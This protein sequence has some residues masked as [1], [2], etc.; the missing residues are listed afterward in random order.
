MKEVKPDSTAIE[1]SRAC[2]AFPV[3]GWGQC[4]DDIAVDDGLSWVLLFF[5]EALLTS[6]GQIV[7]T[8]R[9]DISA[10]PLAGNTLGVGVLT[11]RFFL[12][13]LLALLFAIC[14]VSGRKV[15]TSL[16]SCDTE[17]RNH[18]APKLGENVDRVFLELF[19]GVE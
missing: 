12:F 16:V 8:K 9:P 15:E 5:H 14:H 6:S 13:R 3:L 7:N 1:V 18:N 17:R 2:W 4:C 19:R 11:C 10:G